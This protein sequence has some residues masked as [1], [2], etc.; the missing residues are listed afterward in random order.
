LPQ[1]HVIRTYRIYLRDP[2]N[3]VGRAYEVDAASD[4][5]A[6]DRALITLNDQAMYAYAEVWERVRLV[7][8]VR[9]GE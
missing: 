2:S 9:R 3:V 4:E 7:C 8:T 6:R 1:A 5:A